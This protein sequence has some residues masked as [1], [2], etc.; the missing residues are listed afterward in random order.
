MNIESDEF[1]AYSTHQPLILGVLDLYK[2]QFVLELG[3]GLYSTPLFKGTFYMGIENNKEWIAEIEKKLGISII[4][5]NLGNIGISVYLPSMTQ[6]QKDGIINYYKNLPLPQNRPNLLFV[7]NYPSCRALAINTLKERFD[8]IMFHDAEPGTFDVD[9]YNIVDFSWFNTYYL[10]TSAN[11]TGLMVRE[12]RGYEA[13]LKS[14]QPHIDEYLKTHSLIT[15]MKLDN[16][17][18]S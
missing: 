10:K 9:G 4:Y 7:D 18:Q 17:Y 3:V 1:Y 11:W 2:P 16:K 5:H 6:E 12:D 8:L 13:L 14:T 15:M